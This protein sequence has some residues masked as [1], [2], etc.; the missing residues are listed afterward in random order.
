MNLEHRKPELLAPAGGWEQLHY[1]IF[2]GADAVYLAADRFGMR[3]R[4]ANFALDEMPEVV[5]Y[6]HERDVKVHVTCNIMMHDADIFSLP[7]YLE[8]MQEAGVDALIIG[9]LGAMRLARK[10]AP[11]VDVHVSTQASVCNVEAALAWHDMGASRIVLARELSLEQIAEMRRA[12]PRELELEAFVHGAMCMAYSSRCLISD[13]LANR[14]AL[15]G[16]CAQSCRWKYTLEE[17]KRPG[18]HIPIEQDAR[19]SYIMNAQDMNMLS[20]LDELAQAGVDSIKIEGRNKKAFYVATVVNA[21]RQVLDGADPSAMQDELEMVSHRPYGTGFYFGPATQ[22]P[23]SDDY[24]RNCIW[25]GEVESCDLSSAGADAGAATWT[26]GVRVRNRFGMGDVVEAISPGRTTVSFEPLSIR[27]M[28]EYTTD[29][30]EQGVPYPVQD[31][32]RTMELYL[33]ESPVELHPHDILRVR[34]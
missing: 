18:V 23:D 9:D 13:F 31:A 1:A 12:L 10:H 26:V 17:E 5:S 11:E 15:G 27:H 22:S 28:P 30:I 29:E 2:Y 8:A 4:A 19:G 25:A 33:V 3:Q 24:I 34:H 21:Y 14:S 16:H 20:H 6:A 7:P 32:T